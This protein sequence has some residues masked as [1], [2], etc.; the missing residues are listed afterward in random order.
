MKKIIL[1]FSLVILSIVVKA[2]LTIVTDNSW[3]TSISSPSLGWNSNTSSGWTG[4]MIWSSP[5]AGVASC[6][7]AL[8]IGCN[9]IWDNANTSLATVYFRKTFNLASLCG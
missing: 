6:G 2:Q 9:S 7:F 8:P 3:Q 1:L 5:S 4:G